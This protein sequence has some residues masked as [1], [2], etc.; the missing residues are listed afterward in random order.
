MVWKT[1]KP[2]KGAQTFLL[3][4]LEILLCDEHIIFFC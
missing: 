1:G 4:P 2:N 3:N